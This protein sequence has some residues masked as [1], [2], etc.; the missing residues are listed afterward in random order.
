MLYTVY[1]VSA[2]HV[3]CALWL[4]VK[5]MRAVLSTCLLPTEQALRL[6]LAEESWR[7]WSGS[8]SWQEGIFGGILYLP[9]TAFSFSHSD[10]T[11]PGSNAF[12]CCACARARAHT[13]RYCAKALAQVKHHIHFMPH[14]TALSVHQSPVYQQ[15]SRAGHHLQNP[16]SAWSVWKV[17][18]GG[19]GGSGRR[20]RRVQLQPLSLKDQSL[21]AV[22]NCVLCL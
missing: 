2:R 7:V 14:I 11:M 1:A 3:R 21:F 17:G 18:R 20:E 22:F 15:A 4:C 5:H 13:L 8:E 19:E 6:R 16:S 12:Y 9:R 10:D